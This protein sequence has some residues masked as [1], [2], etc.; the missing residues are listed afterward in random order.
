MAESAG[1]EPASLLRETLVWQ[2]GASPSD[3]LSI[4]LSKNDRI[5]VGPLGVEPTKGL[6]LMQLRS[7]TGLVN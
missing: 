5:L 2:T 4:E 3:A 7:A 6:L 1:I